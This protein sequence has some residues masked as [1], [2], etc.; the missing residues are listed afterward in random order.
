MRK[1]KKR[2]KRF[3]IDPGEAAAKEIERMDRLGK[4]ETPRGRRKDDATLDTG[5]KGK[6]S[7]TNLR[8]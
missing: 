6:A 7:A 8:G 1:K 2:K 5:I 4:Q 3:F